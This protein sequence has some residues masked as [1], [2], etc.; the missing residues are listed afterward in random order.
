MEG[1][2]SAEAQPAEAPLRCPT[3]PSPIAEVI[4]KRPMK[5]L[6]AKV[7]EPAT[8]KAAL[9]EDSTTA[10]SKEVPPAGKVRSIV[11]K[12]G[13]SA[14]SVPSA[15][16]QTMV[17]ATPKAA[18]VE[19]RRRKQQGSPLP[20]II[21][22]VEFREQTRMLIEV[23]GE[24]LEKTM[25]GLR[26]YLLRIAHLRFD[27]ALPQRS[28]VWPCVKQL[29]TRYSRE[30]GVTLLQ[31]VGDSIQRIIAADDQTV[32]RQLLNIEV[33]WFLAQFGW[34]YYKEVPPACNFV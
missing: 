2:P 5:V 32:Y 12:P 1:E 11:L 26:Q 18:P 20:Q 22:T 19:E 17:I 14:A 24:E 27:Q 29:K 31:S 4:N 8:K 3:R 25:H 33:L 21:V 7:A 30:E 28:H 9:S 16:R 34:P 10:K 23:H 6:Q 13:S 15:G